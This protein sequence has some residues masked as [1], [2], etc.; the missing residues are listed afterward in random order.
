[1]SI[2]KK[3]K[4]GS[5]WV[6]KMV[7]QYGLKPT[8]TAKKVPKKSIKGAPKSTHKKIIKSVKKISPPKSRYVKKA[9]P[10]LAPVRR[11]RTKPK[12]GIS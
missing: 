1:M 5:K 2:P 7:K 9:P 10:S 12:R 6:K 8:K 11:T 4:V 3:K